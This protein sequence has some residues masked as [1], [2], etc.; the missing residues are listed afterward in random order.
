MCCSCLV[1]IVEFVANLVKEISEITCSEC[2]MI[3]HQAVSETNRCTVS[4]IKRCRAIVRLRK[5]VLIDRE[6]LSEAGAMSKRS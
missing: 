1:F 2:E 3:I 6:R 4:V 5:S